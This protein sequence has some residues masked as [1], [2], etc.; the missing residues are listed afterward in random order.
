[1]PSGGP[2]DSTSPTINSTY[3]DSA[4]VNFSDNRLRLSFD[5]WMNRSSI[6]SAVFFSPAIR[7]YDI[8]WGGKDAE[9]IL[10]EPLK[11]NRTYSLTLT[12]ALKDIRGNALGESYTL[13]FSTGS[14]L[15]SGSITGRVYDELNRPASGIL[16]CAYLLPDSSSAEPDTLNPGLVEPDYI[17][18]TNR[19][20]FFT[21]SY[22]AEG[23]YRVVGIKDENSN[24]KLDFG[25]EQFAV[26]THWPIKS[27]MHDLTMRLTMRDT[28]SIELQTV[29]P[30]TRHLISA[31]FDREILLDSL[32]KNIFGLYDSTDLKPLKIYDFYT[33]IQNKSPYLFM[34]TDSLIADHFYALQ[35]KTVWDKMGNNGRD[36]RGEFFGI[37][38]PDTAKALFKKPFPDSSTHVLLNQIPD[39]TGW[40]LE[41]QFSRAINR[42]SVQQA[43]ELYVQT[44]DTLALLPVSLNFTDARN[45]LVQPENGF[46]LGVW[47]KLVLNHSAIKDALERPTLDSTY[48]I[49]FQI[50]DSDMFGGIEGFLNIPRSTKA[51]VSAWPLGK[52]KAYRMVSSQNGLKATFEF[53]NIPEGKYVLSAFIPETEERINPY[54]SWNGGQPFPTLPAEPF[55]IGKDTLRVRKRWTTSDV[56]LN[57][58]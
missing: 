50:A 22:L 15:D 11:P 37:A 30:I 24:L 33:E 46:Q 17:A 29:T 25:R 32:T 7:D 42:E 58:K 41:L 56:F 49:H 40:P 16:V 13:A 19:N 28:L 2:K 47:Y 4:S 3:P 39:K 55:V 54:Q 36:L 38:E 18:Q 23:Y 14:V 52:S 51:I 9:F 20:G 27:G 5:K 57:F 31:R 53:Q 44:T 10:Y 35:V 21:L 45:L 26:P 34:V 8:E 12:N 6:N 48:N 43:L 1:M